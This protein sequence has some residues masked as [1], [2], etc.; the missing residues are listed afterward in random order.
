MA[1][2]RTV[3]TEGAD[4]AYDVEGQGPLLLLVVGGNGDA[5]R[6]V[7]LSAL[8][9][10]DYTVV[11]YDRRA[12]WRSS[13]NT[14]VDLDMAQQGRDAA[15]IIR[16]LGS[17]K[18]L[19]FGNSG[20]AN[21][22]IKLTEDHP[23]LV[24]GLVAHEPAVIGIL[25]DADHWNRFMAEVYELFIEQGPGPAM[26]KFAES[27]VGFD[28][29]SAAPGDQG[30]NMAHF[31][32]YEYLSIGKYVPNL[33]SIRQ[34]GVPVITAAGTLS[35]EAYYARTARVM[36]EKL[37]GRYVEMKGNHLAFVIDPP[38]FAAEL[39]SILQQF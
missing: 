2:F 17:E 25:P 38:T 28:A 24:K 34:S 26:R 21:I 19:V 16:A 37:G 11:R 8:L 23:E 3:H 30:G 6:Y 5:S 1:R 29:P 12:S 7:P 20:G 9:A 10:E 35:A 32:R 22:A 33:D 13:G 39:Q 14:E 36:A 18:A 31:M 4:I 27:L 15:A